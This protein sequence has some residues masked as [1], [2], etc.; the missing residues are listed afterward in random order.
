DRNKLQSRQFLDEWVAY[1][2]LLRLGALSHRRGE[3][4][5]FDQRGNHD[6]FNTHVS[7]AAANPFETYSAT[8]TPNYAHTLSFP[9][10][11]Y[12]FVGVDAC[13]HGTAR[14]FNFFGNV[15]TS[16]MDHIASH[17]FDTT[18][19]GMSWS[20]VS[21]NIS[22]I[23]NG[24][25]HRLVYNVGARML[26]HQPTGLLELE[27]GD[28]KKH[29]AFRLVAVDNDVISFTDLEIHGFDR[30]AS[31]VNVSS[32]QVPEFTNKLLKGQRPPI[33]LIT[34][35]KDNK[36]VIPDREPHDR[37]RTSRHIRFLVYT[38]DPNPSIRVYLDGKLVP[39]SATSYHGTGSPW[40]SFPGADASP[41]AEAHVPLYKTSWDPSR[42]DDNR[43]HVLSVVVS[44]AYNHTATARNVFRVD[45]AV[46]T[47][48]LVQDVGLFSEWVIQAN[49]PLIFMEM[50]LAWYFIVMGSLLYVK[51]FADGM[52][53]KGVYGDW[54]NRL[55][56]ELRRIDHDAFTGQG[57]QS[58]RDNLYWLWNANL[59]RVCEMSQQARLFYPLYGFGLYMSLGPFFIGEMI[60]AAEDWRHRYAGFHLTGLW[61]A[62]GSFVPL[63]DTWLQGLHE[64]IYSY[65]PLVVYL[66]FCCTRPSRLYFSGN[67]RAHYPVHRSWYVRLFVFLCCM[68]QAS[69]AYTPSLFYGWI[70]L[71]LSPM[72][73]WYVGWACYAILK[74]AT[75]EEKMD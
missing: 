31:R 35:P 14:P 16:D 37:T 4:F 43:T 51:R 46:R 48:D 57:G 30:L 66:S 25:L 19:S 21:Q 68:Y 15:D 63:A 28:M 11:N 54:K 26:A 52:V 64:L 18:S 55:S 2:E 45:G 38:H 29:G 71:V 36:F 75:V 12:S 23:L 6:C 65:I 61:F 8:K 17:S 50:W 7:T 33:I 44:D 70:S 47:E 67:P 72:K 40:R 39:E 42:Y 69:Q 53:R 62:D 58:V 49:F 22:V 1:S 34:N 27:L 3:R 10:G 56:K 24:H 60:P 13:A 9:F 5:W 32:A 59:L 73:S 20:Q 41:E 74:R